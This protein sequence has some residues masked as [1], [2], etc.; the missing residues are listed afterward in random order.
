M[1]NYYEF[2]PVVQEMLFKNISYIGPS[3][4]KDSNCWGQDIAK[5]IS[6]SMENTRLSSFIFK[7]KGS[8]ENKLK[9]SW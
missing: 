2:G 4:N 1:S 6:K 5:S 8:K 7:T 3:A 9:I